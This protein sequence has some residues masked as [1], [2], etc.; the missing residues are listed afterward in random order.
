MSIPIRQD[1]IVTIDS[2]NKYVEIDWNVPGTNFIRNAEQ[3][4]RNDRL[5]TIVDDKAT[6]IALSSTIVYKATDIGSIKDFIGKN[7]GKTK[8]ELT[9]MHIYLKMPNSDGGKNKRRRS[10]KKHKRKSRKN[11]TRYAR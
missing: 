7:L 4:E 5:Y 6:D 9:N 8:E 11:K 1:K 3:Q 2:N 10:T